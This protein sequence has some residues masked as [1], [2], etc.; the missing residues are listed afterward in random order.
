MSHFVIIL[1]TVNFLFG[2]FLRLRHKHFV[3]GFG[4]GSFCS[5]LF[6]KVN[7][8]PPFFRRKNDLVFKSNLVKSA[9][10][11]GSETCVRVAPRRRL[12]AAPSRRVSTHSRVYGEEP[13]SVSGREEEERQRLCCEKHKGKLRSLLLLLRPTKNT[14]TPK[15]SS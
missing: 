11:S 7:F 6:Y 8:S 2:S 15:R 1:I 10:P 5:F 14:R 13:H 9:D 3:S 12:A 4:G